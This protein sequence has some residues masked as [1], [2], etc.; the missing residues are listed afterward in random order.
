MKKLN[1]ARF[2]DEFALAGRGLLLTTR[3]KSFWLAFII[4][5]IVFGTLIN[6]LASGFTS[7]QLIGACLSSGDFGGAFKIIWGA[8]L[9]IFGVGREFT[10]FALN[11][12]L[13]LFQSVLIALVVFVFKHNKKT[14]RAQK[15]ETAKPKSQIQ[16]ADSGALESSAIVAGLAVLGSGCPTCGTTLLAP[17]LGAI[18]SGTTGAVKLAG[19]LSLVFNIV[20]ILLAILVFRKLGYQTYAIIK[21][22]EFK[23]KHNEKNS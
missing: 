20:A 19:A 13:T 4:T 6:L 1:L 7:F 12:V 16:S 9:A 5:F 15:A 8:F 10:D 11:F 18:L 14:K 23:E 21:S 2:F 3:K 22:E 17:I